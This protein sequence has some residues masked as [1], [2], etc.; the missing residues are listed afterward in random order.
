[1]TPDKLI[2]TS[3]EIQRSVQQKLQERALREEKSKSNSHDSRSTDRVERKSADYDNHSR[4]RSR[5]KSI[6]SSKF[7]SPK[8]QREN[9]ATHEKQWDD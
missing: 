7:M 9:S 3:K 2:R 4:S 1:M 8:R 6:D 5:S